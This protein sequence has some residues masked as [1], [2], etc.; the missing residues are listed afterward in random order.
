MLKFGQVINIET[1]ERKSVNKP[2]EELKDKI[3]KEDKLR[4][5]ELEE[6]EVR[7]LQLLYIT[8]CSWP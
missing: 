5:H 2:A 4:S 8:L 1:L 6:V 3:S 7:S